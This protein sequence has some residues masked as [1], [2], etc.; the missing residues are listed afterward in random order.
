MGGRGGSS[1]YDW[2]NDAG[3]AWETSAERKAK[4]EQA[5]AEV[6]AKFKAEQDR[7]NKMSES[8]RKAERLKNLKVASDSLTR[9]QSGQK[10]R[11]LSIGGRVF[12]TAE[13]IDNYYDNEYKKGRDLIET[14]N[15]MNRALGT[16]GGVTIAGKV[17]TSSEDL[18][19]HYKSEAQKSKDI[20]K[21]L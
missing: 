5:K 7:L 3:P 19:K 4:S 21:N 2:R 9:K 10:Q 1:S 12:H 11:V 20:L 6:Q 15:A 13:E 16:S 8:E 18:R 14:T 17:Y